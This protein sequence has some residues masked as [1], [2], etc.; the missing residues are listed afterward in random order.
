MIFGSSIGGDGV[1]PR[2]IRADSFLVLQESRRD[3]SAIVAR[4][5]TLGAEPNTNRA[6]HVAQRLLSYS[7]RASTPSQSRS[8]PPLGPLQDQFAV[9]RRDSSQTVTTSSGIISDL[10]SLRRWSN[11][12]GLTAPSLTALEQIQ[13]S[14]QHCRSDSRATSVLSR[15]TPSPRSSIYNTNPAPIRIRLLIVQEML[16]NDDAEEVPPVPGLPPNIDLH[17]GSAF[18]NNL[19]AEFEVD[20]VIRAGNLAQEQRYTLM[21]RQEV[22]LMTGL[23]GPQSED[24]SLCPT[25]P[26]VH[27]AL[28][29]INEHPLDTASTTAR[30]PS[31]SRDSSVGRGRGTLGTLRELQESPMVQERRGHESSETATVESLDAAMPKSHTTATSLEDLDESERLS[32]GAS[33]SDDSMSE[34]SDYTDVSLLEAF[35]SNPIPFSPV[36]L[37]ILVKIK[38]DVLALVRERVQTFLR[39]RDGQHCHANEG[40]SDSPGSE[41]ASPSTQEGTS[42]WNQRNS[43]KRA[44][45]DKQDGDGPDRGDDGGDKK[46]R[47]PQTASQTLLE[48]RLRKLACPFYKRYPDQKWPKRSCHGPGWSSHHRVM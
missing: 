20:Q 10:N 1:F 30:S 29:I 39:S 17:R 8:P 45:S 41:S 11:S 15:S 6:L 31:E 33:D 14:A 22:D 4:R 43:R 23:D 42:S 19:G 46:R 38:E 24:S 16:S 26:A 5:G 40:G 37:S 27:D 3:Q 12:T 34:F 47:N 48:S 28:S 36:L 9:T 7:S 44:L 2:G 35:D 21:A 13:M 18:L 32:P 25:L